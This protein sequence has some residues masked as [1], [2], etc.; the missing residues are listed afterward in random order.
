MTAP[1]KWFVVVGRIY[2]DE[3]DSPRVIQASSMVVARVAFEQLMLAERD[4][5]REVLA[6]GWSAIGIAYDPDDVGNE[7]ANT[8]YADTIIDCGE[9]KPTIVASYYAVPK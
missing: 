5:E 2:G 6:R 1:L 8:V 3:E 7:D 4:R 9:H